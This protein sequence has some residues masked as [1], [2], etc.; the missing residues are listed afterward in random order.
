M[1]A[2]CNITNKRSRDRLRFN[3]QGEDQRSKA[4]KPGYSSKN[5]DRISDRFVPSGL[6]ASKP[7][8]CYQLSALCLVHDQTIVKKV[9]NGHI[10]VPT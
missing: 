2:N 10:A 5:V 4:A 9:A 3:F 8:F 7:R 1:D 6:D